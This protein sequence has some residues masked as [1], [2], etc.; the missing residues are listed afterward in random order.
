MECWNFKPTQT[1]LLSNITPLLH[2]S[3]TPVHM[4]NLKFLSR[5]LKS[6]LCFKF[7]VL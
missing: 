2:H 4:S 6:A 5:A 3:I 7:N 1:S